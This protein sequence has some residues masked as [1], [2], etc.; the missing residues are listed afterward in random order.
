MATE[1]EAVVWCPT[2]K[3]DKY[4]VLRV[5]TGNAGVYEHRTNPPGKGGVHKCECGANLERKA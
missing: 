3:V 2:C 1:I 4:D 5:P